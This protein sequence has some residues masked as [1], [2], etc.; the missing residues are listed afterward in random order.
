[1]STRPHSAALVA[2]SATTPIWPSKAPIWQHR[3]STRRPHCIPRGRVVRGDEIT[4]TVAYLLSDAANLISI[5]IV[6][7]DAGRAARAR[8]SRGARVPIKI[9][10]AGPFASLRPQGDQPWPWRFSSEF[11][12]GAWAGNCRWSGRDRPIAAPKGPS[13]TRSG[14]SRRR[15]PI[16]ERHGLG[17]RTLLGW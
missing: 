11:T 12:A 8:P 15:L 5:T 2:P 4:D 6:P 13:A 7:V 10:P 1:M 3:P 14:P 17:R 9:G 16:S